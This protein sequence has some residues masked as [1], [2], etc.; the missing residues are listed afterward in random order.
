MSRAALIAA[1]CAGALLLVAPA[2]AQ[3]PVSGRTVDAYPASLAFDAAGFALASW[4]GLQGATADAARPF[5][6][7]AKRKPGA[8][9]HAAPALPPT[10]TSHTVA[11]DRTG[12]VALATTRQ[13]PPSRHRSRTSVVVNV[14]TT[15]VLQFARGVLIDSGPPR[16]VTAEG[17]QPTL[18]LPKV[19]FVPADSIYVAWQRTY[20]RSRAGVWLAGVRRFNRAIPARR[21]ARGGGEPFLAFAADGSGVLAWRAGRRVVARLRTAAGHWTAARTAATV[22]ASMEIEHVALAVGP[23]R[24]SLVAVVATRRAATGIRVR[25]SV[26]SWVA[27]A[28]WR[29]G[30]L[31]EYTV[32]GSVSNS[33]V[34]GSG[35]R[36]LPLFESQGR[37]LVAWPRLVDGHV[38]ASVTELAPEATGIGTR[39]ALDVS[40]PAFDA[41]IEDVAAGPDGRFAVAWFD[42]GDGRGSPS[43]S[44]VD[45][46]G[47]VTTTPRLATERALVGAQVAYDPTSGR[48]TVVWS[49]GDP[50]TG[51]QIVAMP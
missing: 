34:T 50:A 21:M 20:P 4:T 10:I 31:G 38:R 46:T 48:P 18:A 3:T 13:T 32:Q 11:L 43:L 22:P 6:A 33:H 7:V 51:H 19:A 28:G 36:A 1:C 14:A 47:A 2:V 35:L 15:G 41:S 17:P 27:G 8:S 25:A 26:H 45:A 49:Q 5:V 23:G 12:R 40:D 44:E 24:R 9:W 39:P 37:M 30:V 16:P 42:L 29:A